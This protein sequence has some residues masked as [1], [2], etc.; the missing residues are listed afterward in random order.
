ML[1]NKAK[2]LKELKYK[3]YGV[4]NMLKALE[5]VRMG[6]MIQRQARKAFNVRREAL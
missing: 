3:H 4:D 6:K 5:A 2:P 1:N